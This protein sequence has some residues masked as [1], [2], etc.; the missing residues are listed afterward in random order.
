M[1]VQDSNTA[2]EVS[3]WRGNCIC[4]QKQC[5]TE[6]IQSHLEQQSLQPVSPDDY[7]VV[8]IPC[9]MSLQLLHL[10]ILSSGAG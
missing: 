3:L 1:R 7:L 2:N 5:Q 10:C 4:M 8:E 6:A 9:P